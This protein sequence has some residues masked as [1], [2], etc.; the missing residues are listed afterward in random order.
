MRKIM[1]TLLLA[2]LSMALLTFLTTLS[3]CSYTQKPS[4]SV[5]NYE[6]SYEIDE[7]ELQELVKADLNEETPSEVCDAVNLDARDAIIIR[8]TPAQ[9][10][11]QRIAQREHLDELGRNN[12]R[13]IIYGNFTPAADDVD[14]NT[15]ER[16]VFADNINAFGYSVVIDG[17]HG[18][19]YFSPHFSTIYMNIGSHSH[20]SA[21]FIEED[22]TRLIQ[23]IEDS[24]FRNWQERYSSSRPAQNTSSRAWRIGIQFT[25]GTMLRSRGDGMFEDAFPPDG[26][27][28]IFA[29]F[30]RTLGDEII[31]RHNAE[32]RDTE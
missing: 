22:L 21:T 27:F 14:L 24:N 9:L 23:A 10:E 11:E 2:I 6:I 8:I 31:E 15:I 7:E 20:Y 32:S 28:D 25:D 1:P 26:E 17:R 19:V 5:I 16:F 18:R 3:G 12:L 30:V 29:D 4:L 13:H